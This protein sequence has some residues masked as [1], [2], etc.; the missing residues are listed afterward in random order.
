MTVVYIAEKK[1]DIR[2]N[3]MQERKWN[4]SLLY[5]DRKKNVIG[6]RCTQSAENE[7]GDVFL[8]RS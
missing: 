5:F 2:E 4:N 6:E 3:W 8:H 1:T 7:Y